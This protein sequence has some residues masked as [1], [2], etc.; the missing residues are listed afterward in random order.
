MGGCIHQNGL[1]D[2]S[3]G[4]VQD[5][6]HDALVVFCYKGV[7]AEAKLNIPKMCPGVGYLDPKVATL[8]VPLLFNNLGPWA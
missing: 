2:M 7:M 3:H 1:R 6:I 5:K 4:G 8:C